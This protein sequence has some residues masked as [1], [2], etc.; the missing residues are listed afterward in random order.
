MSDP[1]VTVQI[2]KFRLYPTPAQEVV[3]G[4]HCADARLVW[5]LAVGQQS[6]FDRVRHPNTLGLGA[7]PAVTCRSVKPPN[8]AQR[9]QQLTQA[10]REFDWL[11]AGSVIVQQQALRDF[12][13]ALT[14]FF[15]NPG[16]FGR[17][18]FRRR[19]VHDGFRITK[20]TA[21]DVTVLSRKWATMRIP[22]IGD[23]KFRL[24]RS[25][26]VGDVKSFR[27]K[28]DRSG[29]WFIAF[30][31]IPKPIPPPRN[32][33]VTG[34]DRG[35]V[36][37]LAHPDGSFDDLP[38]RI[39]DLDRQVRRLQRRLSRAKKGSNRRGKLRQRIARLKARIADIRREFIEQTT[40][41]IARAHDLIRIEGLRVVN[42]VKSARGTVDD[43]GVNVA[44][45]SGLNRA[46]LNQGW[47][48]WATRLDQKAPGRVELLNPAYTSQTCH[49]CGNTAA[50]QREN[51]ALFRCVNPAC[52]W[53]GNA[54]TNSAQILQAGGVKTIRSAHG[55]GVAAQG[56]L[57]LPE[58][59]NCEPQPAPA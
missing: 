6:W 51:Q 7:G 8:S 32:G 33:L 17:P 34:I 19:G 53:T 29:R 49:K 5:N 26:P 45:K 12:D 2:V 57:G 46:I 15:K 59:L 38:T 47:S 58:P 4:S 25:I 55:P 13:Q 10:R 16:H 40:T 21:S 52:G 23:V 22:K 24:S 11:A 3:L 1:V 56:G 18:T 50:E 39:N 37:T 14:N 36:H 28:R 27:V 54:D 9:F 41:R 35:V 31:L 30:A 43:P 48:Q 20:T 44:A 42:M